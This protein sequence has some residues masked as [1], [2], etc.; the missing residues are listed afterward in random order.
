MKNTTTL[1]A[2]ISML[3]RC[4]S[5][6]FKYRISWM[7][8]LCPVLSEF[9]GQEGHEQVHESEG[10]YCEDWE[11]RQGIQVVDHWQ[12]GG[13]NWSLQVHVFPRWI[14]N[15]TSQVSLCSHSLS[16]LEVTKSIF[17]ENHFMFASVSVRRQLSNACCNFTIRRCI[18]SD[19]VIFICDLRM[20]CKW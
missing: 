12:E 2:L 9:P 18:D 19:Y 10:K 20:P 14:L 7:T 11:V 8:R 16:Y 13:H 4:R 6:L 15:Q 5:R 1:R 17:L 3:S